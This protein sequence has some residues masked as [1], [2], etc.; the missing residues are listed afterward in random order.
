MTIVMNIHNEYIEDISYSF[1]CIFER[2]AI[3]NP[4]GNC[5]KD[6]GTFAGA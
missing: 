5:A 6:Y 3:C 4:I 2:I 1:S